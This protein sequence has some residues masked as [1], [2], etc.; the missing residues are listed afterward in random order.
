MTSPHSEKPSFFPEMSLFAWMLSGFLGKGA[1][2]Q[3]PFSFAQPTPGAMPGLTKDELMAVLLCVGGSRL[4]AT[5]A[6]RGREPPQNHN[7][8][9]EN[10]KPRRKASMEPG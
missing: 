1:L 7:F 9:R 6:I 8:P 3:G 5:Q 10:F 2:E 4:E